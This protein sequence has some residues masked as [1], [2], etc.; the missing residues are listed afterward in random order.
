MQVV[1]FLESYKLRRRLSEVI[2][3][4][5]KTSYGESDRNLLVVLSGKL[6]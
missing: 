6:I 5:Q 2:E 3:T 4:P 1:N